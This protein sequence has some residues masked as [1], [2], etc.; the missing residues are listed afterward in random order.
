MYVSVYII[1]GLVFLIKLTL[2]ENNNFTR[3]IKKNDHF[4]TLY[5]ISNCQGTSPFNSYFFFSYFFYLNSL[6][7]TYMCMCIICNLMYIIRVLV[8]SVDFLLWKMTNHLSFLKLSST[9]V[10]TSHPNSPNIV[11]TFIRS[12]SSIYFVD[13]VNTIYRRA[14]WYRMATFPFWATSS[15]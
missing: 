11:L 8:L 1:S 6:F 9:N 3:H 15:L 14:I 10:N 5:C 7:H 2:K 13:T 4:P 12:I